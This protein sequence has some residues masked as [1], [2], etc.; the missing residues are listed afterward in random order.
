[1]WSRG[2]ARRVFWW[3]LW[4]YIYIFFKGFGLDQS[5]SFQK[6]CCASICTTTTK[7]EFF[8]SIETFLFRL[9]V[10]SRALGCGAR[11]GPA[12][13]PRCKCGSRPSGACS[14]RSKSRNLAR[15]HGVALR[16]ARA[17]QAHTNPETSFLIFHLSLLLFLKYHSSRPRLG[18]HGTAAARQAI[19]FVTATNGASA[20]GFVSMRVC[21]CHCRIL[22]Q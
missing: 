3:R 9:P 21:A 20:Y 7:I 15:N 18:S 13:I 14:R 5:H 6:W 2:S 10:L 19:P 12:C 22:Q 4:R 16:P 8:P 1:M 17:N 11:R